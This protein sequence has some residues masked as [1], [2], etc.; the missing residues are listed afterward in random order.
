MDLHSELIALRTA[1]DGN[2][3]AT[4]EAIRETERL[5][6]FEFP[7]D[8]V[9]FFLLCDGGEGFWGE[10]YLRINALEDIRFRNTNPDSQRYF[11]DIVVFGG[12]GG[13]EWYAFL[14]GHRWTIVVREPIAGPDYDHIR[15]KSFFDFIRDLKARPFVVP[16]PD[17]AR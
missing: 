12:D 10:R 5:V 16:P 8:L 7:P 1:L 15:G 6:D 4:L 2:P 11:S 13:S 14:R 9:E 3:P 17:P